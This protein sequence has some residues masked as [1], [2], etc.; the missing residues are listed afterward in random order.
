MK[1]FYLVLFITCFVLLACDTGSAKLEINTNMGQPDEQGFTQ[2]YTNDPHYY[3]YHFWVLS[4]NINTQNTYQVELKKISGAPGPAYGL[5]FGGVDNSNYFCIGLSTNGH[6]IIARKSE[7]DWTIIQDWERSNLLKTGFNTINTIK[8]L[9]SG[10]RYDISLN[11]THIYQ[12]TDSEI[13]GNRIGY[14]MDVGSKENESF[15][16]TPVDTRFRQL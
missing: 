13:N 1:K 9:K 2:F 3:G 7:G 5:I 10:S 4:Q 11:D 8:V 12:F 6:Y 15:P 14:F 16:N